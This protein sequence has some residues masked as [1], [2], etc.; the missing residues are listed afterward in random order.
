MRRRSL[1]E[2]VDGLAAQLEA[3]PGADAL[4]VPRD[5]LEPMIDATRRFL[6]VV[7]GARRI[8]GEDGDG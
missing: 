8:E 1:A 5:L 3:R 6:V 4:C 2:R 7:E